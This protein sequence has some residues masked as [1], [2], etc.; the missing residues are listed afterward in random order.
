MKKT[1]RKGVDE[2][3]GVWRRKVNGRKE[4]RCR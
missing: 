1:R 2:G 4:R 3:W